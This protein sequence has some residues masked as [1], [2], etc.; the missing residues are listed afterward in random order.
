MFDGGAQIELLTQEDEFDFGDSN[1][2]EEDYNN[3]RVDEKEGPAEKNL[4][5]VTAA[6][7]PVFEAP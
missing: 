6:K 7:E 2:D 5:S 4:N 1:D 3:R